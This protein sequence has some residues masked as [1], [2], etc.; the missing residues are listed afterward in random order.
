MIDA[1][2]F[3][4][5]LILLLP[6][7]IILKF[8]K[9][10]IG[11]S[12]GTVALSYVL[13]IVVD[14]SLLYVGAIFGL[15]APFAFALTVL[16]WLSIG[17]V[18]LSFLRQLISHSAFITAGFLLWVR[19]QWQLL[20]FVTSTSVVYILV[21]SSRII[22]DY[23]VAQTYLPIA[24]VIF[25]TNRF[26]EGIGLGF[27]TV[28]KPVGI[29]TIYAWT[30]AFT[31]SS[32]SESFRLM[33]LIPYLIL[34]ALTYQ[35]VSE[36]SKSARVG[37]VGA[38]LF[39]VLPFNGRWLLYN[40]F[41]PDIFYYPLIFVSLYLLIQYY[42]KPRGSLLFLVGLALGAASLLKAQA[43]FSVLAAIV[44]LCFMMVKKRAW[45]SIPIFLT[46][47]AGVFATLLLTGGLAFPSPSEL[48]QGLL[49]AGGLSI[50]A[51]LTACVVVMFLLARRFRSI[52]RLASSPLRVR[53]EHM[54]ML[55]VTLGA[56]GSL[57]Y[58][59]NALRLH[60]II[61]T[62]GI[63]I[64]HLGWATATLT[65][66]QP[67]PSATPFISAFQYLIYFV[68]MFADPALI[69]LTMIVPAAIG[70]IVLRKKVTAHLLIVSFFFF[71]YLACLLGEVV[72]LGYPAALEYNPRD[73]F[74]LILLLIAVAAVGL[75]SLIP[76]NESSEFGLPLSLAVLFI[77]FF[78]MIQSQFLTLFPSISQNQYHLLSMSFLS[79]LPQFFG[80]SS[81]TTIYWIA[82]GSF[83]VIISD[84]AM[85]IL[86]LGILI[87]SPLLLIGIATFL[88]RRAPSRWS[89]SGFMDATSQKR[90]TRNVRPLVSNCALVF[91]ILVLLVL[92][93]VQVAGVAGGTGSQQH[94]Q[95]VSEFGQWY[96]L[97]TGNGVT[98]GDGILAFGSPDGLTYFLPGVKILDLSIATNLAYVAPF[99]NGSAF[100][101]TQS[102]ENLGIDYVMYSPL[103]GIFDQHVNASLS[104]VLNSPGLSLRVA[105]A[106]SLI[107]Y[108]LGPFSTSSRTFYLSGW[109][110]YSSYT[111]VTTGK[112]TSNSSGVYI[113]LPAVNSLGR[114]TTISPSYVGFKVSAQ[115]FVY[116]Q[117]K[118]STNAAIDLRLFFTNA[119]S[120]RPQ[121]ETS[122]DL[123][124][125]QA[126][127]HQGAI[128]RSL[129]DHAGLSVYLV[130]LS[131]KSV[132]D[133]PAWV[134]LSNM[135]I[136]TPTN[137]R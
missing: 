32:V 134:Q 77:G 113:G 66:L 40:A 58:L 112:F 91:L 69:G 54:I 62:S 83:A 25:N 24:Q 46:A 68:L 128:E 99:I 96:L 109:T 115:D 74:P 70:L 28:L 67:A 43:L 4:T 11:S 125:W 34:V 85:K 41:Y 48:T 100:E 51:L 56:L 95:T 61:W 117:L 33:P 129:G 23:D 111:N 89:G 63:S 71:S 72:L 107:L 38:A 37:A 127:P 2:A 123:L 136:L 97:P 30:Y 104:G 110:I 133:Q 78:S 57:W 75:D 126:A 135:S 15:F 114:I 59:L 27:G 101:L 3:L 55:L 120:G 26:P 19:R 105:T 84:N 45:L 79:R 29:S 47:P 31:N 7:Y 73:L 18:S 118:S 106:G 82:H 1:S 52:G 64:P 44:V 20:A 13:S 102:L 116:A 65:S 121:G 119:T 76:S 103:M 98:K 81:M 21:L 60:S 130:V 87:G 122:L 35:V 14:F 108:R 124:Y 12:I 94:T 93:Y 80:L 137:I 39:L 88:R 92:P 42:D 49:S 36:V 17:Y 16:L 9:I 90:L 5:P 131:I 50:E 53:L 132:N 6:G 10:D 22:L 8:R 86:S